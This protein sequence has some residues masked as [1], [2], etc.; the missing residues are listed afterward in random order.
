VSGIED[1]EIEWIGDSKDV[2]SA[3]PYEVKVALGF[4]LRKVQRGENP[5]NARPLTDV[6]KGVWELREQDARIWY[7]VAYLPRSGNLVHVLHCFEKKSR[8][9]PKNAVRTILERFKLVR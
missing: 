8:E 3:W 9:T 6:G 5:T 7:R 1:A 4:E 2:L